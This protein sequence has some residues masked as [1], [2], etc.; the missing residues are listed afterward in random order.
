ME[1]ERKLEEVSSRTL[2]KLRKMSPE[3]ANSLNPVIPNASSLKWSDVF[4]KVSIY[5]GKT[6]KFMLEYSII[7]V[8][9]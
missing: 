2:E 1:V 4:K 5:Y 7:A 9:R 6:L 3:V 8:F